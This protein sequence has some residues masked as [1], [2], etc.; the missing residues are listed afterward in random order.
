MPHNNNQTSGRC[1]QCGEVMP[2]AHDCNA[3]REARAL[4]EAAKRANSPESAQRLGDAAY[5][6]VTK[7]EARA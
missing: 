7:A 4:F 6:K 3:A 1:D 2:I 5:Q